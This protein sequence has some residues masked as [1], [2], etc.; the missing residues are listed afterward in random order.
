MFL[1]TSYFGIF[2]LAIIA[3]KSFAGEP[4]LTN[5]CAL[6]GVNTPS[7][8]SGFLMDSECKNAYVLPPNIGKIQVTSVQQNQNLGICPAL[9]IDQDIVHESAKTKL[10]I[11]QKINKMIED[12]APLQKERDKLFVI[13]NKKKAEYDSATLILDNAKVKEKSLMERVLEN[14][15]AYD[16]IV[17]IGGTSI[18][19][20]AARDRYE[21]SLA[22]YKIFISGELVLTEN[23]YLNSKKE[24]QKYSDEFAYYDTKYVESLKPLSDLQ[25]MV[26]DIERSA[27]ESYKK[28]VNLEGLTANMIFK[29]NSDELVSSFNNSNQHLKITW[30]QMPIKEALFSASLKDTS[31]LPDSSISAVIDSKIPGIKSQNLSNIDINSNLPSLNEQNNSSS[32][33]FGSV[34]G[35]V[36]LN[37]NGACVYYTNVNTPAPG[38][39]INNISANISMNVTYTYQAKL[40]RYFLAR[41]NLKNMVSKIENK[42]TSGGWFTSQT[43][44]SIVENKNSND[45]FEIKF[46]G[47]YSYTQE[48]QNEITREEKALL[49]DR[50][51]RQFAVFNAGSTPP[52][53]ISPPPSGV[54]Y[55][56][57]G[58][59]K[60][61]HLYCQIGSLVLGTVGSIFGSSNALATFQ[62]KSNIWVENR[63]EGF[64]IQ[65]RSG[66]LTFSN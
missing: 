12:Y 53:L 59:Q 27:M 63:V 15:S 5:K 32:Y 65:D 25:R 8:S 2:S 1:K 22:E 40:N 3:G 14:K 21:N 17:I 29:V 56:S 37:L 9:K 16:R 61:Y 46:G 4:T 33:P 18:E 11:I 36:R 57:N 35:F 30:Q 66:T 55:A 51:L 38:S 34:S 49:I 42:S 10:M 52:S 45:W 6:E 20:Q 48:E 7:N 31:S 23:K 44:H 47:D 43:L 58:L 64:Q 13:K 26:D 62:A 39:N 19:I 24:Y 60:C 28:Y 41:Y 50:A 54:M